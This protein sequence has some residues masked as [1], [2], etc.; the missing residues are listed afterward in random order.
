MGYRYRICGLL[1]ESEL[2]LPA[3]PAPPSDSASLPDVRVIRQQ[4][5]PVEATI[6]RTGEEFAVEGDTVTF[7]YVDVGLFAVTGCN[8]IRVDPLPDVNP[9]LVQRYVLSA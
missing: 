5:A 1:F 9:A 7:R 3:F 4:I 6:R 8:L 2:A